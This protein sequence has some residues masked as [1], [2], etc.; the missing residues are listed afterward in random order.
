MADA[1]DA[2]QQTITSNKVG[3][4]RRS[5]CGDERLRRA[6]MVESGRDLELPRPHSFSLDGGE[7]CTAPSRPG[8]VDVLRIPLPNKV[9]GRGRVGHV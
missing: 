9:K 6:S 3:V 1:G 5:V 2:N 7:Y 8:P 4:W